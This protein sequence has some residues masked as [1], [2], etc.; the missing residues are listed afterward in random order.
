VAD[1]LGE[2]E[3]NLTEKMMSQANSQTD[4][5]VPTKEERADDLSTL[6]EVGGFTRTWTVVKLRKYIAALEHVEAER[7]EAI[8]ERERVLEDYGDLHT[9]YEEVCAERDAAVKDRDAGWHRAFEVIR[10]RDALRAQL[11]ALQSR[12]AGDGSATTARKAKAVDECSDCGI[13]SCRTQHGLFAGMCQTCLLN[14][15]KKNA[16][17]ILAASSNARR[18]AEAEESL[19]TAHGLIILKDMEIEKLKGAI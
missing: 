12:P 8:K 7:D 17:F 2:R 15:A 1:T 14:F 16:P 13:E 4:A 11:A 5:G 18:L 9:C 3:G 10:E 6:E 19:K